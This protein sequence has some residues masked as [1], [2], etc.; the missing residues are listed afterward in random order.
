MQLLPSCN[1]YNHAT[2]TII[3]LSQSCNLYNHIIILESIIKNAKPQP[4]HRY[5]DFALL[6]DF[7]YS[8]VL[9]CIGEPIVLDKKYIWR[10]IWIFYRKLSLFSGIYSYIYSYSS[11]TGLTSRNIIRT[12]CIMQLLPSCIYNHATVTNIELLQSCN[13]YNHG[14]VTIMHL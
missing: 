11:Q 3:Q 6:R 2:V 13:C 4:K 9:C 14:T 1:C 10:H 8:P 12:L 5:E 7:I